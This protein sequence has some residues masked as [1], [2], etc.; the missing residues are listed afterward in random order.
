M[1]TEEIFT[2]S[3][4]QYDTK[5]INTYNVN[6]GRIIDT[7][8][9]YID[10]GDWVPFGHWEYEYNTKGLI[11]QETLVY[12]D[13]T[14]AH[15]INY[16]YDANDLRVRMSTSQLEYGEWKEDNVW[17]FDYASPT[18][19][20]KVTAD[21]VLYRPP[22]LYTFEYKD[23]QVRKM[24][25][26]NSRGQLLYIME[27]EYDDNKKAVT[28]DFGWQSRHLDFIT[29]PHQHNITKK[30]MT[31]PGMDPSH[32]NYNDHQNSYTATFEY[33]AQGYPILETRQYAD[34]TQVTKK[35]TYQCK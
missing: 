5:A 27:F 31:T 2:S 10:N 24:P 19:L 13:N 25:F 11:E 35:L 18:Q 7:E 17:M 32:P 15:R 33:N 1:T 23:K 8:I 26:Y 22:V 30:T 9:F 16:T 12:T 20:S 6:T 34:G 21:V 3:S 14:I 4:T 28:A 29:F